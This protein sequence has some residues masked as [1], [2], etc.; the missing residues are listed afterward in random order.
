MIINTDSN[1]LDI[2]N[3]QSVYHDL[4]HYAK[5]QDDLIELESLESRRRAGISAR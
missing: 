3:S 2:S 4:P 5:N 1:I